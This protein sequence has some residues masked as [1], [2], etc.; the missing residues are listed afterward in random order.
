MSARRAS[1]AAALLLLAAS[2]ARKAPPS[3][4]PPDI[5]PPRIVST[6]PDSA[7]ARVALDARLSITFSK[8]M[9]PTATGNAVSLAPRVG[10][11]QRRWSGR[12]LTVV[13]D[14]LL[15]SNQT[16]TLFVAPTA[17]DRHGNALPLGKAIV[18]STADSFPPGVIEGTIDARGFPV[19]GTYLWCYRGSRAPDS[20]ARDFDALGVAND[21]GRFR[22]P[23][24]PVPATYRLWA[25]ADLNHNRSFEPD[26]DVLAPADTSI[27][28][29]AE[30]PVVGDL[31]LRVRNPRAPGHVRGLVSD[32]TGDTLGVLRVIAIA[33]ED[34][35]R[36]VIVDA[37]AKRTYDLQ[38]SAGTWFVRAWR[39][40]DRNRAWRQDVEP[41]S[42]IR[43]IR[44]EPAEEVNDV[45]LTLKHWIQP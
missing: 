20:T 26:H 11:R 15:K 45:G 6:A 35:T 23:G 10:I 30:H 21:Q 31:S 43:E 37:D 19:E 5:T 25:F 33:S 42:E 32:P 24:L 41:A 22:I 9:E 27:E 28:L 12:T 1:S 17:R 8:P 3:G 13:L 29:T 4:G 40:E 39:D 44:L 34:S 36:R 18:F 38:L 7:A 14:T 16:Y 2:C